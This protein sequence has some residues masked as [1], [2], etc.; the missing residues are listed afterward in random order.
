[1]DEQQRSTRAQR[2]T[3]F[4]VVSQDHVGV[5]STLVLSDLRE[6]RITDAVVDLVTRTAAAVARTRR[7]A[8]PSGSRTWCQADVDDLVG[9]FFAKP[10]R[11]FDLAN[12]AGTGDDA[13][14]LFRGMTEKAVKRVAIDRFRKG[15]RGV[16]HE[17]VNRRVAARADIDAVPPQHWAIDPWQASPHWGGDDADLV[18]SAGSVP[19]VE[20]KW[21]ED[22]DRQAPSGTGATV[23]AICTAVLCR[24]QSPVMQPVVRNIV[25]DRIIGPDLGHVV[26]SEALPEPTTRSPSAKPDWVD[27]EVA[28]LEA[29]VIAASLSAEDLALLPYLH[30]LKIADT[31]HKYPTTR[32][33]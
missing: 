16:L 9:E 26:D 1:M 4:L 10:G 7:I 22:S 23:D 17:R 30:G 2:R 13:G 11:I 6:G 14:S 18:A 3:V 5:W 32:R 20:Q 19:V 21:S 25:C 24:A 15:P 28:E 31:A 12:S 8:T 29:S 27:L 33:S